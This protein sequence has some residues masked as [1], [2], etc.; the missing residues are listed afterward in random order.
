MTLF[1]LP[2]LQFGA[3]ALVALVVFLILTGRLVPRRQLEDL[4]EDRDARLAAAERQ[5]QT[6]QAAYEAAVMGRKT[7]QDHVS[8]L[9]EAALT[10]QD[11]I[12]ALPMLPSQI[13][14]A[15]GDATDTT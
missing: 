4:R 12:R 14:E 10:A 5:V 7:A 1:G 8:Q 3:G 13:S 9:M 2:E 15:R 6:W 11:V